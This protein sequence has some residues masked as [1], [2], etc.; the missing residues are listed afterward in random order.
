ML[1]LAAAMVLAA[2]TV[3]AND[4]PMCGDMDAGK[5]MD[6]LSLKLDLTDKQKDQIKPLVD[7]KGKKMDAAADQAKAAM[8]SAKDEFE[9]GLD[10]ILTAKQKEKWKAWQ[11]MDDGGMHE[12][13]H[14]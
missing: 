10:K 1:A 8:K 14:H 3:L 9:A 13:M 4:C 6:M 11:K 7:T 2:G 5:K 12:G